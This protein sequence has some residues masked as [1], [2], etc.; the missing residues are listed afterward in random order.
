MLFSLIAIGD[1]VLRKNANMFHL[2]FG[3]GDVLS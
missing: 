1:E 3:G 2:G